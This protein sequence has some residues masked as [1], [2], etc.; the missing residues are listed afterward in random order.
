M[1]ASFSSNTIMINQPQHHQHCTGTLLAHGK[2]NEATGE[3]GMAGLV[4]NIGR[5]GS[6]FYEVQAGVGPFTSL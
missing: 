2:R 4:V 6:L 1:T 3:E 5:F